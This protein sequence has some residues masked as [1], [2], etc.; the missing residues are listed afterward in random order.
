MAQQPELS[1]QLLKEISI[2]MESCQPRRLNRNLRG[3]LLSMLMAQKDG[4]CFDLDDLLMDIAY[5]F[6]LLDAMEAV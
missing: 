4:Y 1:P 5:L 2:F 6:E 3:L